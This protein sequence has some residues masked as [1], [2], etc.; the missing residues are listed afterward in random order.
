MT[1]PYVILGAGG[2]SKVLVEILRSM[3]MEISAIVA[4]VVPDIPQFNGLI[5]HN[6]DAIILSFNPQSIQLVNAIGSLPNQVN[7]RMQVN[8]QFKQAGFTF[9][10]VVAASATVS[11]YV[12]IENGVQIMPRAIVNSC[13][14]GENSIINSGAIV[15]HDVSIGSD[16][17][18]APGATICGGVSIGSNVHIG[19]GATIIQGLNVGDGALVGAGSVVTKDIPSKAV[20]YPARSFTRKELSEDE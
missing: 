16:C 6:N 15:E 13:K 11:S 19:A 2:H 5:I 17:H 1:K 12:Y 18:I 14:I 3:N 20:H 8:S 7:R 9:A 10:S 4:P